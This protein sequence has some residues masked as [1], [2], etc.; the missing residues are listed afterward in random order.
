MIRTYPFFATAISNL[1]GTF[2]RSVEEGEFEQEKPMKLRKELEY[3]LK[4]CH[5]FEINNNTKNLLVLTKTPKNNDMIK[6][7]FKTIFID[8]EFK[9]KDLKNLGVNI[10]FDIMGLLIDQHKIGSPQIDK[11]QTEIGEV[12]TITTLLKE[13]TKE[14][15]NIKIHRFDA[16]MNIYDDYKF[17]NLKNKRKISNPVIKRKKAEVEK[18]FIHLFTINFLN[19]INDPQIKIISIDTTKQNQKRIKKGKIAIP[20]RNVICLTGELKRHID[21]LC[22]KNIWTYKYRFWVRGHFR[23][24]RNPRYGVNTGKRIWVAPFIK[25]KGVLYKKTY[26]VDKKDEEISMQDD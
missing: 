6:L 14:K 5:L 26:L 21:E 22:N 24:L 19:L 20:T 8:V 4:H 23:T 9:K 15:N 7:P 11:N 3:Y 10:G 13:E 2:F 17:L 18:K 12:L 16:H 1:Q 25:G